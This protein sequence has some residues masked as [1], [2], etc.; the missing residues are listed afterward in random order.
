V[1]SAILAVYGDITCDVL[2]ARVRAASNALD[3]SCERGTSA[4]MFTPRCSLVQPQVCSTRIGCARTLPTMNTM[5]VSDS[6]VPS[7]YVGGFATQ[8]VLTRQPKGLLSGDAGRRSEDSWLQ[9]ERAHTKATGWRA[10][11]HRHARHPVRVVPPERTDGRIGLSGA[12][13]SKSDLDSTSK[14]QVVFPEGA[15]GYHD[16][17]REALRNSAMMAWWTTCRERRRE[18]R[19]GAERRQRAGLS[20]AHAP[21]RADA[22][23]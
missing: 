12:K 11:W 7:L 4:A 8:R 23:C 19:V 22:R 17:T 9:Q 16:R 6:H 3:S 5:P 13:R 18:C 14:S 1:D 2:S 20:T 21:A 10:W 15:A